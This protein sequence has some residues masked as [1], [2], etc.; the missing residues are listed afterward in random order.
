MISDDK[1][2]DDDSGVDFRLIGMLWSA[3]YW[4][5]AVYLR[6]NNVSEIRCKIVILCGFVVLFSI[7]MSFDIFL[8][9]LRQV[10]WY[11]MIL[12]YFDVDYL[13]WNLCF[14]TW[15]LCVCLFISILKIFVCFWSNK[16]ISGEWFC[17]AFFF[18]FGSFLYILNIHLGGQISH[19]SKFGFYVL[20]KPVR[21]P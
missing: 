8:S 2:N 11:Q 20:Y 17:K 14:Q 6:V 13:F 10:I 7:L 21:S 9:S 1:G 19:F 4:L 5:H 3:N 12:T 15:N 16:I 18:D